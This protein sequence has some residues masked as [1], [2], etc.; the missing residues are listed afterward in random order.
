[1]ARKGFIIGR[2]INLGA[3]FA[4]GAGAFDSIG[5]AGAAQL[6]GG[7][8]SKGAS[9]IGGIAKTQF[10]GSFAAGAGATLGQRLRGGLS[11]VSPTFARAES[12]A[13]GI[14]SQGITDQINKSKLDE[15]RQTAIDKATPFD[16]SSILSDEM[17]NI[18]GMQEGILQLIKGFDID[19][20]GGT[21]V[22]EFK[23]GKERGEKDGSY[24]RTIINF[25]N[26]KLGETN[27]RVGLLKTNI[28]T[29]I[30]KMNLSSEG[31]V[32]TPGSEG[33]TSLDDIRDM[34]KDPQLAGTV[35]KKLAAQVLAID[36]V[37]RQRTALLN[38]RNAAIATMS[39]QQALQ[40]VQTE[41]ARAKAAKDLGGGT[42]AKTEQQ[43]ILLAARER[44]NDEKGGNATQQE[45]L[46]AANEIK[47]EQARALV[48]TS[49]SGEELI[50]NID[51][52]NPDE[53]L[54]N[55]AQAQLA[56]GTISAGLRTAN[57][58]AGILVP[59]S[60]EL[61][62]KTSAAVK[63]VKSFD[64]FIKV[65][66]TISPRNPIAELRTIDEFLLGTS[67]FTS[68]GS[69]VTSFIGII[70]RLESSIIAGQD[71]LNNPD[72]QLSTEQR[73]A[74]VLAV[75]ERVSLLSQL[76]STSTIKIKTRRI[77]D[78]TEREI[79]NVDMSAFDKTRRLSLAKELKTRLLE[80][81]GGA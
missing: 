25:M 27:K 39:T 35:D 78:M 8:L 17:K 64:Q 61:A 74:I 77:D 1:M 48:G 36:K 2:A 43:Q 32:T 29:L 5:A 70:N 58:I 79:A 19:G 59:G 42:A 80:I 7:S 28:Q 49:K 47:A 38:G 62:Q 15:I 21:S 3:R 65:G 55:S 11:A 51:R 72:L 40:Q 63:A 71:A 76:P 9:V 4:V 6:G 12:L 18:P 73:Q 81:K 53:F 45:I 26:T 54:L 22:A 50:A 68:P 23:I 16:P 60:R 30:D 57:F 13:A 31:V 67:P 10:A 37:E 75:S 46:D 69:N 44:A 34:L 52:R 56:T 41:A 33:F 14:K 24:Q 20:K 66:L